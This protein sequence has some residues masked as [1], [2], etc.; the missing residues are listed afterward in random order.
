[1]RAQATTRGARACERE[2]AALLSAGTRGA[3]GGLPPARLLAGWTRE[4]RLAF[5]RWAPV[6][7]VLPGV[8]RWPLPERRTLLDVIRAKGSLRESDFV[9]RFDAHRRLRRAVVGLVGKG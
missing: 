7:L 3:A 2:A 9:H 5:T 4:E 1:M 6:V 8:A